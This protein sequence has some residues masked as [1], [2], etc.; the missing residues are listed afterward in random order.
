MMQDGSEEGIIHIAW[1]EY[2]GNC[3]FCFMTLPEKRIRPVLV[4]FSLLL[5]LPEEGRILNIKPPFVLCDG[6]GDV[7]G[8]SQGQEVVSLQQVQEAH[9]RVIGQLVARRLN[10]N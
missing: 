10:V 5:I 6:C 8:I 3:D 7:A 9:I 2:S 1:E 4:D